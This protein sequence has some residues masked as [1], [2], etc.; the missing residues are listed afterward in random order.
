MNTVEPIRDF[1]LILDM[2]DYLKGKKNQRDYVLFMFGLYSGLRISDILPLK[3]RDVR[4]ADCI[5][6]IEKKTKKKRRVVINDDLKAVIKE[7][8]KN[9]KDYELLFTSSR[10]KRNEPLTRQRVWQILNDT[11]N[12]FDYKHP[13]GCHTLRKTF[14]YW[15]Y[16]ETKDAASIMDILNH[17]DISVTK[18]YI[19]VTQDSNENM[20]RKLSFK[21]K[22]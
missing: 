3:V 16:Q 5:Y 18:R 9:K 13:M 2:Q 15:L 20:V 4:N 19:G 21:K 14:G 22:H 10:G 6:L 8:I 7:Y 11:A 17:S 12:F 1:D